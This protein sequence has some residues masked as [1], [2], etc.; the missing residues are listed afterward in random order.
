MAYTTM[1]NAIAIAVCLEKAPRRFLGA[2]LLRELD[3]FG[4]QGA[5]G[6]RLEVAFE[7]RHEAG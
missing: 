4:T 6:L 1:N 7:V 2:W 3:I 5:L